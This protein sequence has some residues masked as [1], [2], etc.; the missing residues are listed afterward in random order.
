MQLHLLRHGIAI[1]RDDPSCPPEPERFLTKKGAR[2]TRA[3]A[4][5]LAALKIE[6]DAVLSSPYR[7]ARQT[8]EIACKEIG[9]KAGIRETEALL[10]EADPDAILALLAELAVGSVLCAGHAPN[11]DEVAE[12]H[13]PIV[14]TKRGTP[15]AKLVPVEE[16][17]PASLLGSVSYDREEDLL[18]PVE[19]AWDA[20][21]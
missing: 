18:A 17:E 3:A 8:A 12:T 16:A 10:P 14:V 9:V 21:A 11:L 1:D 19:D 4:R 7:R 15:V 20:E 6:P 2:R 13:V 5:G